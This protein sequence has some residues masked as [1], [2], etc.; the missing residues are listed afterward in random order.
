MACTGHLLAISLKDYDWCNLLEWHGA[1]CGSLYCETVCYTLAVELLSKS[2]MR[3][4]VANVMVKAQYIMGN[5]IVHIGDHK[6]VKFVE[7]V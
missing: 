1:Q 6:E 2:Y 4:V 7:L 5:G 3:Q